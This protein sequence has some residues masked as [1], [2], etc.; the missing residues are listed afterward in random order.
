MNTLLSLMNSIEQE[1]RT[2][3]DSYDAKKKSLADKK[4]EELKQLFL[5]YEQETQLLLE[6]KREVF[7]KLIVK[8]KKLQKE[9]S[10]ATASPSCHFR[11]A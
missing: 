3:Y 2:I 10:D 8:N 7:L 11:R 1:A 5:E 4:E 6:A 9:V